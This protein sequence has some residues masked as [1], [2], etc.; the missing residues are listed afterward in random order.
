MFRFQAWFVIEES[1]IDY[2][3]EFHGVKEIFEISGVDLFVIQVLHS[4]NNT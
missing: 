2:S 4:V 3:I 1:D